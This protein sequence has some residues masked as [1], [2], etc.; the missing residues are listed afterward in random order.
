M[1]TV[2]GWS[3]P[4]NAGPE[5]NTDDREGHPTIARSKTIYFHRVGK[6]SYDIFRA[7]SVNGKYNPAEK[8][9]DA[10]NTTDFI[11]GEPFVAPD[12]SFLIFVSAGRAD[13]IAA[14]SNTCDLYISFRKNNG[15]WTPAKIMGSKVLSE[16]EE[17]WPRVSPDGKYLFFSSNRDKNPPFP[18]IY[19][20]NAGIIDELKPEDLK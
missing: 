5:I 7:E 20:I 1:R 8:L 3:D 13:R 19:W 10:I 16:S 11:E 9:G 14:D 12:E 6:N 18:D 15:E 17:N 2:S 4:I